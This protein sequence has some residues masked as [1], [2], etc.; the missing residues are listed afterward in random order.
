MTDSNE[1]WY[2]KGQMLN[3]CRDEENRG[4]FTAL[5]SMMQKMS[6]SY[7][8]SKEEA[9][10]LARQEGKWSDRDVESAAHLVFDYGM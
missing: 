8:V 5:M 10:R 9:I 3:D 4:D 2:D 6:R 7:G 1:T